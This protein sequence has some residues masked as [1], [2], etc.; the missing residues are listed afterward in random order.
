VPGVE[1]GDFPVVLAGD[2]IDLFSNND[3][4]EEYSWFWHK[5]TVVSVSGEITDSPANS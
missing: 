2:P 5:D 1:Y 3:D 4:I